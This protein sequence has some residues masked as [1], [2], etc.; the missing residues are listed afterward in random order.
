MT[1]SLPIICVLFPAPDFALS[2]FS[3][4]RSLHLCSSSFYFSPSFVLSFIPPVLFLPLIFLSLFHPHPLVTHRPPSFLF[5]SLLGYQTVISSLYIFSLHMSL[6]LHLL[7][8][9]RNCS[10]SLTVK[11]S[12]PPMSPLCFSQF[13]WSSWLF[14]NAP[15]PRPPS[16]PL[17]PPP[18]HYLFPIHFSSPWSLK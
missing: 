17:S 11:S 12:I 4:L 16:F 1:G 14:C 3:A 7:Y 10:S 2:P 18:L 9:M 13:S 6:S 8:K 5:L 15:L